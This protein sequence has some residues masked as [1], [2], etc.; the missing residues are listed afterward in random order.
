[1]VLFALAL[2]A[3]L[4]RAEIIERFRAAPITQVEGLV[5][6]FASCPS[7]MRREYQMPIASFVADICRRLYRAETQKPRRFENP[8][9]VVHVGGVTTNVPDVVERLDT[10]ADGALITRIYLPA[11]GFADR[12]RLRLAA[13]KAF[14][15]AVKGETLTDAEA[16]RAFARADPAFRIAEVFREIAAWRAG[17]RGAEDDE[18][19]LKLVRSVHEPG[20]AHR[21][22][23]LTFASRLFLYPP[24]YDLRFGGKYDCCSF[25]EAIPI[26]KDDPA[27]RFVAFL[28]AGEV[29]VFGGGHGPAMDEAVVAYSEFLRAL[30]SGKTGERELGLMLDD[31]DDKL[32][33]LLQ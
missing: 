31:A 29:L 12:D 18:K 17:E 15:R 9:I 21:E 10:R 2:F 20:V 4:T 30:A 11:P 16:T 5:Q 3:T 28:K 19:F 22:D 23:V 32:K 13:V 1:M 8:G 6:T 33:G 26:A 24:Q 7:E 27:L 14:Y 25:R